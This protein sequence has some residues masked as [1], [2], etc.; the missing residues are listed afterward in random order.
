MRPLICCYFRQYIASVYAEKNLTKGT[1][2]GLVQRMSNVSKR[3]EAP[4][5]YKIQDYY[6]TLK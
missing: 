3:S 2:P 6:Y 5:L 1:L 4:F